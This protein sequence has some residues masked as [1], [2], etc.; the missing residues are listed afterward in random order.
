MYL[1]S[2]D[3]YRLKWNVFS[4]IQLQSVLLNIC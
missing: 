1:G 3:T 2:T 4:I